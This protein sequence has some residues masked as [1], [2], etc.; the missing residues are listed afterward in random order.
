M[1]KKFPFPSYRGSQRPLTG[2]GSKGPGQKGYL[3]QLAKEAFVFLTAKGAIE[4]ETE[5]EFRQRESI[6][7][8]GR[9]ISEAVNGDFELIEARFLMLMGRTKRALES[10]IKADTNPERQ[11]RFKLAE[12]CKERGLDVPALEGASVKRIWAV[13]FNIKNAPKRKASAA[14]T[15]KLTAE[16]AKA[17]KEERYEDAAG[18]KK[19]I[20]A[21]L[22]PD[23]ADDDDIPF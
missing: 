12:L 8:C 19:K 20:E 3:A 5:K 17:V 21:L 16:M 11:A 4:G 15:S 1:K 13:F 6:E 14:D 23:A 2:Q 18:L 9:R 22:K 7:A 10:A